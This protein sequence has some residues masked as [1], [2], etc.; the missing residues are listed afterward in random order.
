[1][2]STNTSYTIYLYLYRRNSRWQY[3]SYIIP[4]YHTHHPNCTCRDPPG[5]LVH[6]TFLLKTHTQKWS[7]S[8]AFLLPPQKGTRLKHGMPETMA[9]EEERRRERR[10]KK[11]RKEEEE[12]RRK[13]KRKEEEERRRGKK[14]RKEEEESMAVNRTVYQNI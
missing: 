13:K 2:K 8:Q 9:K 4:M 6:V 10:G 12:R 14:K 11:K 3:Q 1:M 5:I 7:L